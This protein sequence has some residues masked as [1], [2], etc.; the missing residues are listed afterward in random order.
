MSGISGAQPTASELAKV[1][2]A[3]RWSV[4][5]RQWLWELKAVDPPGAQGTLRLATSDDLA[6]VS[7]WRS[8]DPAMPL[9]EV[10]CARLINA[11][12]LFVWDDGEPCSLAGVLRHTEGSAALG[13]LYTPPELRNK[14]HGTAAVAAWS[15]QA[16]DR[17]KRCFFYT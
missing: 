4:H 11:R 6:V 15:R 13:I 8:R 9:D 1:S 17:G 10:F 12:W 3:D 14:G 7:E 5:S 2:F 16:L